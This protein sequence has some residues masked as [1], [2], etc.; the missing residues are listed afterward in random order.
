M[1]SVAGWLKASSENQTA[2]SKLKYI[3]LYWHE[4]AWL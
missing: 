3:D 2:S 4:G 1:G